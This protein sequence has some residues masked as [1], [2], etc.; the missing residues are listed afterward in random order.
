M[1]SLSAHDLLEV[2]ERGLAQSPLVRALLL[3]GLAVPESSW[4]NLAVLSIGRRDAL[5]LGLREQLFGARMSGVAVCPACGERL[6]FTVPTTDLLAA[7]NDSDTSR[8]ADEHE[9][10]VDG[11]RLRMR[12]LNSA[13]LLAVT[14]TDPAATADALLARCVSAKRKGK[15]LAVERLPGRVRQAAVDWLASADPLAD[16]QLQMH[17]P[18][19]SHAWELTFDIAGFLWREL[20]EWAL[21]IVRDVHDLARAYAWR[22]VDILNLS[23]LRRQLYLEMAYQ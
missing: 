1:Q 14:G 15:S 11:Y 17:C 6:E 18:A 20:E 12:V 9:M 21:R 23:S 16:I 2:W 5:L 7:S 13:D 19:C 10:E 3:S 22:E 4:A 8:P